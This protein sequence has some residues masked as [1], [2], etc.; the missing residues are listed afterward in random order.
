MPGMGRANTRSNNSVLAADFKATEFLGAK[1][2]NDP[3]RLHNW[4][5]REKYGGRLRD[6]RDRTKKK[7]KKIN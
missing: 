4:R 6:L 1:R 5:A 2:N 3:Q 7:K